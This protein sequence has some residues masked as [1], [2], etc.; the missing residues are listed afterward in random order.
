MDAREPELKKELEATV[1]A[2]RELGPEYESELIESFLEK[3]DSSVDN[4][5]RRQIAEQ[6]M[7]VARGARPVAPPPVSGST[8]GERYG[9]GII[10]LVLAVPLSAIGATNGHLLGLIV[11]WL[12]ITGVNFVHAKRRWPGQQRSEHEAERRY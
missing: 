3:L 10:S 11:T 7:V 5:V 12:G 2:R 4:R 6:Q 8:F 9:F 1:H